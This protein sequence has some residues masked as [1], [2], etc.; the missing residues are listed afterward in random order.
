MASAAA[1]AGSVPANYEQ[2]LGPLLF[3]PYAIDLVKRL[4]RDLNRVL[5]IACGTGRVTRHLATLL[6]PNGQLSATDLNPDMISVARTVVTDGRIEW[7]VADAQELSFPDNNFDAVVCQYGVMFFPDKLKAFSEA[8]RVLKVGGRFL[9]NTWDRIDAIPA[10]AVI[11]RVM[12][13]TFGA[14]APNFLEQGPFSFYDT[15]KIRGLMEAAGFKNINIELV[16]ITSSYSAADDVV[17]GFVDGSPLISY[18]SEKNPA[19]I[20][21]IKEKIK[22]QLVA[23]FGE[24]SDK[25]SLQAFVCDGTK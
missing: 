17:R 3:E 6:E 4:P 1:Y 9:F 5:E 20:A 16:K 12:K 11:E 19:G 24:S 10:V 7:S 8:F 25:V 21:E 14:D 23:N 22:Q 2:Y 18:L 15:D 13:E